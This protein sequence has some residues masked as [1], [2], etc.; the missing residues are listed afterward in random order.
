MKR[1][2]GTTRKDLQL[3]QKEDAK[4]PLFTSP[5]SG[6]FPGDTFPTVRLLLQQLRAENIPAPALQTLLPPLRPARYRPLRAAPLLQKPPRG[7]SSR[8]AL[9]RVGPAVLGKGREQQESQQQQRRQRQRQRQ[10]CFLGRGGPGGRRGSGAS[11]ARAARRSPADPT[12]PKRPRSAPA[13]LRRQSSVPWVLGLRLLQSHGDTLH[14]QAAASLRTAPGS[15][16][17]GAPVLTGHLRPWLARWRVEAPGGATCSLVQPR[18]GGLR[19]PR[20]QPRRGRGRM[21]PRWEPTGVPTVLSLRAGA[22]RAAR[23]DRRRPGSPPPGSS[24]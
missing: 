22:P 4:A 13:P 19:E 21:E 23:W 15:P 17:F 8:P 18:R 11:H 12:E 10:R 6:A 5:P 16:A 7:Q 14:I 3:V 20:F 2:S 1:A 24:C 9:T